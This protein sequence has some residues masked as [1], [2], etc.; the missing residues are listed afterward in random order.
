MANLFE[1]I[2]NT[3]MSDLHEAI[4]KKEKKNPISVLNQYLRQCELEVEK[5]RKLVEKTLSS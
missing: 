3:V 1:R 2:K 5:V 4:D